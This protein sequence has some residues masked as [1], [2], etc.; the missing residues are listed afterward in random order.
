MDKVLQFCRRNT[1]LLT[2]GTIFLSMHYIWLQMQ[3]DTDFV[4]KKQQKEEIK[5]G[6]MTFKNP[7]LSTKEAEKDKKD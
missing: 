3:F 4:S 6:W 2:C 7:Q 5:L 1:G